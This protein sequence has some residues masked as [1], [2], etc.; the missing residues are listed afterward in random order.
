VTV[1]LHQLRRAPNGGKAIVANHLN[2]YAKGFHIQPPGR[3]AAFRLQ[4]LIE[5]FPSVSDLVTR[6]LDVAAQWRLGAATTAINRRRHARWRNEMK[7]RD[8]RPEAKHP[9]SELPY[10]PRVARQY[11]YYVRRFAVATFMVRRI[12]HTETHL[13]YHSDDVPSEIGE[14]D[15]SI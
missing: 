4:D 8:L 10:S 15:G 1:D 6:K 13:V 11:E 9:D 14:I 3:K 2:Q 5:P 7:P 12:M